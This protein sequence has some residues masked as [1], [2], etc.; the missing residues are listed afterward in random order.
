MDLTF[1]YSSDATAAMNSTMSGVTLIFTFIVIIL[2]AY[3]ILKIF[4][5]SKP[6]VEYIVL[7][8]FLIA[9]ATVGRLIGI[10]VP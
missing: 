8:A 1:L 9:I 7:L 3:A 4:E 6:K 5:K 10:A 2:F